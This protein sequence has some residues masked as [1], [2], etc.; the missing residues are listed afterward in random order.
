MDLITFHPDLAVLTNQ[1]DHKGITWPEYDYVL[2]N[3]GDLTPIVVAKVRRNLRP[4]YIIMDGN[5]RACLWAKHKK[6]IPA[7]VM[8]AATTSDEILE[9]E[10][11]N[12]IFRFPHREFLADEETFRQLMD[13][14]LKAALQINETIAQVLDRIRAA[15]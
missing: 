1:V 6:N 4:A 11:S 9:M 13:R 10:G 3:G 2:A 14:A 12:E 8:T 15:R 7:Y 5:H